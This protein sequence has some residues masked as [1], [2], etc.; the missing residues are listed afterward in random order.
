[1]GR[2]I[3]NTAILAKIET[4]AGV[5][6]TPTGAANAILASDV[7]VDV[8]KANN[9]NRNLLRPYFGAS[10]QLVGTAYKS[11]SFSVELA[12]SGTAA[13]APAW[14]ALLQACAMAEALLSSPS[15]VEYTPISTN[16]KTATIYYYDD[17]VVHKMVG[18][19][20]NVKLSGKVGEKPMLM[21]EFIGADGGDATAS[22]PS[23]TLT[24]WKTPPMVTKANVVDITLG[25]TYSVGALSG[26]TV[27]SSQGLEL[28]FSNKAEF[29]ALLSTEEADITD[30][31]IVGSVQFD[32]TAAQEIANLAVVKAN[33][34]QSLGFTIGLSAGNKIIL[35]APGVQLVNPK[36]T[37]VSGRRLI[38]YDIRL[39]PT[40]AGN[41][42]LRIV[43]Q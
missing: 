20:G 41:D 30:R 42:E 11:L 15:R 8:L 39:I 6:A 28:D 26:G 10:E 40:S 29:I 31:E 34:L 21:F 32:L 19:M 25:C 2:S 43:T 12:G 14:G 13:T 16:R 7:T 35:H 17:G 22:L 18:C 4:T 38:G 3:R 36:K 24:A 27:Y 1:M 33:T 23:V 37:E 9:V 5:D